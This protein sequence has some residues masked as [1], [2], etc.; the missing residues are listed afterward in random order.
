MFERSFIHVR[1]SID[2]E[3]QCVFSVR[4]IERHV[5]RRWFSCKEHSKHWQQA[6]VTGGSCIRSCGFRLVVIA[7]H[8]MLGCCNHGRHIMQYVSRRTLTNATNG[9]IMAAGK[10]VRRSK[11][12]R[13]R[14]EFDCRRFNCCQ[15]AQLKKVAHEE[16]TSRMSLVSWLSNW[17]DWTDKLAN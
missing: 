16:R 5:W 14:G 7:Q 10:A 2:A 3:T 8:R 6:V 15:A 12:G 4:A 1:D 13:G 17:L 9:S 11:Q